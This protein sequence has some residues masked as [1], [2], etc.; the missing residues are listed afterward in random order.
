VGEGVLEAYGDSAT[1]P[2][3][4]TLLLKVPGMDPEAALKLQEAC[5]QVGGTGSPICTWSCYMQCHPRTI[6]GW[7]TCGA[8]VCLIRL[9]FTQPPSSPQRLWRA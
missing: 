4:V 7:C 8:F 2:Q 5:R 3:V 1:L 9:I 6:I